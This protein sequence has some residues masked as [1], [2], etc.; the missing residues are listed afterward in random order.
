MRTPKRCDLRFFH[1]KQT[2][3]FEKCSIGHILFKF[4]LY[5]NYNC[6]FKKGGFEVNPKTSANLLKNFAYA[7]AGCAMILS[8][9]ATAFSYD[10]NKNYFTT[11]S[12]I[13]SIAVAFALLAF[14]L[15]IAS[16]II[17]PKEEII[18]RSPFGTNLL[19]ALPAAIGFGLGA[20]FSTVE[21]VKSN[22]TLFF[23]T[24]ILLLLS[25]AHV[26]LCETERK[27]SILG[28]VPPIACALLVAALYFDTSLEMNA[29]M[30]V[31]AQCALLPLMLYFTTE[32]R[33][34]LNR[35][36]PRLSLALALGS[37]ATASLCALAV[38]VACMMGVLSNTNCLAASLVATG[39]NIT[40]LLK[41]KRYPQPVPSP[42]NDTKETDAQ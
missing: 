19:V 30:K 34:L 32:L 13:F 4:V 2:I 8:A 15:S 5:N 14:A 35:E 18:S 25:V 31:T 3:I 12:F 7:G 23:I 36:I 28:F 17:T 39:A 26:L 42:E 27:S 41:L 9:V 33:Y 16:A 20:I 24:T 21:F 1:K 38:P 37:I 10:K 40:L 29:P 22:S 6:D 11:N